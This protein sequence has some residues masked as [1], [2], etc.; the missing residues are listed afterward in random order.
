MS[1]WTALVDDVLVEVLLR[2]PPESVLRFRA[3]SKHWRRITTCP[4][5]LVAYSHRRPLEL[6]G[7]PDG[8]K[9]GV[10]SENLLAGMDPLND[11]PDTVCRCRRFLRFDGILHLVDCR[12][13]LLLF[14]LRQ[15]RFLICNPATRQWA[16]LPSLTPETC[17]F[18]VASGLYFHRPSGEHR[19]LCVGNLPQPGYKYDPAHRAY[20]EGEVVPAAAAADDYV[21]AFHYILSTG[22]G[23]KARRLCPVA[24]GKRGTPSPCLAIG[25]TLYWSRHPEAAAVEENDSSSIVAF[26]TLSETFRAICCPPP[27]VNVDR[28]MQLRLFDMDGTLAVSAAREGSPCMQVWTLG[29]DAGK[30]W[31]CILRLEDLPPPRPF[32][33][34]EAVAVL[35]GGV[36]LVVGS[37]WVVRYDMKEKSTVSSV[38]HS[39]GIRNLSLF[40]YRPS[41]APLTTEPDAQMQMP[42]R[43]GQPLL[44]Y[45]SADGSTCMPL[46][47][48]NNCETWIVPNGS[49]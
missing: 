24:D 2:L 26:D 17:T 10:A 42:C 9:M 29:D 22:A 46:C 7:Y 47:G 30:T 18:V 33:W 5:F 48:S 25:T 11:G 27:L 19:V 43:R 15:W 6:L 41:L 23:A 44:G 39:A 13:G 4:T 16:S 1:S 38:D 40:H 12:D 32:D 49:L 8:Y 28:H 37:G 14:A 3:V 36:L 21:D 20:C 31:A 34:L 35:E 45:C